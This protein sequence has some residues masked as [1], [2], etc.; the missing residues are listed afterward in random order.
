MAEIQSQLKGTELDIQNRKKEIAAVQSQMQIYESRLN[1]TPVREQQLADLSGDYDQQRMNYGLLVKK[2]DDSALATNLEKH[3][4]G[5]Q[6]SVLDPPSYPA[7]PYFPNRLLFTI[8]GV[9]LGLAAAVGTAFMRET[10]DD[11]IHADKE[12]SAVCKVPMLVAIPSLIT[13]SEMAASHW[14][15]KKEVACATATLIA[16]A[17]SA[18]LAF[19]HG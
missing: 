19:Y 4:Q 1:E 12:I 18:L 8:A 9:A 6:F 5:E 15:A 11:R 2:R 3:Q 17:V 10:L 7:T 14:R 16:M 13:A